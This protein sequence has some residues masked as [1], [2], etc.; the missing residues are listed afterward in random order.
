MDYG[1]WGRKEVNKTE[2]ARTSTRRRCAG[3]IVLKQHTSMEFC[4]KRKQRSGVLA[5]WGE[6]VR[7]S[8]IFKSCL[9]IFRW[10]RLPVC[11]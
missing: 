2:H 6:R 3:D 9:F 1:P 10:K 7:K 11:Y 5:Q 4:S 8:W